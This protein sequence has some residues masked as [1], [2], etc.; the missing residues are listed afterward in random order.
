MSTAHGE[1]K[2][3]ASIR[4]ALSYALLS[5]QIFVSL[6]HCCFLI[7]CLVLSLWKHVLKTKGKQ[8]RLIQSQTLQQ[9]Y[10]SLPFTWF[11]YALQRQRNTVQN[12]TSAFYTSSVTRGEHSQSSHHC[13]HQKWFFCL[14]L[15]DCLCLFFHSLSVNLFFLCQSLSLSLKLLFYAFSLCCIY[16]F[17]SL[18]LRHS[19]VYRYTSWCAVFC[20]ERM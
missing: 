7:W 19:D 4:S 6:R 1:W 12:I 17:F 8:N 20:A 5:A 2:L 18:S 15:F 3:L 11:H 9:T 16:L 10:S 13:H 14:S